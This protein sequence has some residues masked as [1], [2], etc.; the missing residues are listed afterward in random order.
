MPVPPGDGR[1]RI[2]HGGRLGR[3]PFGRTADSLWLE[4]CSGWQHLTG[5]GGVESG[6]TSNSDRNG[7][8]AA[9][10]FRE[11]RSQ[12]LPLLMKTDP[13]T[14]R[15]PNPKGYDPN[16]KGYWTQAQ[17]LVQGLSKGAHWVVGA[18]PH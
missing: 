4:Q 15:R 6:G 14:H 17:L 10:G 9:L 11:M 8:A 2:G 13:V 1:A 12:R 5:I 16:P 3:V 7:I 18:L